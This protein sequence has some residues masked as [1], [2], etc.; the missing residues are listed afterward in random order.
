MTV[1][2]CGLQRAAMPVPEECMPRRFLRRRLAAFEA[3]FD[4]PV[5]ELA[6]RFAFELAQV[7]ISL[8]CGELNLGR[9]LGTIE[10][11]LV[12]RAL[13]CGPLGIAPAVRCDCDVLSARSSGC[14]LLRL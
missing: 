1:H 3:A 9:R 12:G 8:V 14:A 5:D 13:V 6:P 10:K 7:R 4:L 2:G 11:T